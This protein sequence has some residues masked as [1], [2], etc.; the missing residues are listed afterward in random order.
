[1]KLVLKAHSH[2]FLIVTAAVS[3]ALIFFFRF[4]GMPAV[5]FSILALLVGFYLAWATTFHFYDKSFKLEVMVEYVLTAL[6]TLVIL[7]GVLL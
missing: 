5:Q 3:I 2:N 1:M 6:L 4:Q 7:Y